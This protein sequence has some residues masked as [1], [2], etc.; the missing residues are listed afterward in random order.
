[1]GDENPDF[2]PKVPKPSASLPGYASCCMFRAHV[3]S[4][5]SSHFVAA[6][7]SCSTI[8]QVGDSVWYDYN[9]DWAEAT[10][11]KV[12]SIIFINIIIHQNMEICKV[13]Q[14][15]YKV[16]VE[17]QYTAH[18]CENTLSNELFCRAVSVY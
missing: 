1:M 3:I 17:S 13:I 6:C 15:S 2:N 14:K 10:I 8:S 4:L 7:L 9:D 16:C 12:G 11:V 5:N 18:S